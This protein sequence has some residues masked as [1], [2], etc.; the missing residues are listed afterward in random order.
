MTAVALKPPCSVEKVQSNC[1]RSGS[2]PL[3]TPVAWLSPRNR[4]QFSPG[5]LAA[6]R[7]E[8]GPDG[9]PTG[10]AS[11]VPRLACP[12]VFPALL[13]KPAVAPAAGCLR[14]RRPL[15]CRVVVAAADCQARGQ[16]AQQHRR[17]SPRPRAVKRHTCR[18]V[19]ANS[20]HWPASE[21]RSTEKGPARAR[22]DGPAA[23]RSD[24]R[25]R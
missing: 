6:G 5:A 7:E 10:L 20:A 21:S 14:G 12:T 17:D 3:A 11:R 4:G 25:T 18:H 22:S 13:G 19:T 9:A 24:Q 8:T 2:V 1:N 15:V 16:E 23:G